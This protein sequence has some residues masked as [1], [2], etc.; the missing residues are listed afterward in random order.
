M[1]RS[2]QCVT[3]VKR[4]ETGRGNQECEKIQKTD[5]IGNLNAGITERGNKEDE[6]IGKSRFDQANAEGYYCANAPIFWPPFT[7][8]LTALCVHFDCPLRAFWLYACAFLFRMRSGSGH[9]DARAIF[10]VRRTY[11]DHKVEIPILDQ[12]SLFVTCAS[13]VL[14]S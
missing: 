8:I 9:G 5:K 1:Q 4:T 13:H 7:C 14:Q 3:F 12:L 10:C 6:P 2:G 11:F